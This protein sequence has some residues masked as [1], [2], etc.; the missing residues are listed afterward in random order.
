M[1][2]ILVLSAIINLFLLYKWLKTR[3]DAKQLAAF[4]TKYRNDLHVT[5]ASMNTLK[6]IGKSTKW[7]HIK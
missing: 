7:S 6:R 4:V 2:K 5:R 1:E 3:K